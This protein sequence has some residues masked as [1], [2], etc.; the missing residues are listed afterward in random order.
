M[1]GKV[2]FNEAWL[3]IQGLIKAHYAHY[4]RHQGTT[5][6]TEVEEFARIANEH[7]LSDAE[8]DR[9]IDR[10]Q[11]YLDDLYRCQ[12]PEQLEKKYELASSA[13][14]AATQKRKQLR[15]KSSKRSSSTP[16]SIRGMR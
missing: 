2:D 9:L 11:R 7:D 10:G 16:T 4:P 6:V 5:D 12:T 14:W 3:D 13:R 1:S 8:Y 15:K